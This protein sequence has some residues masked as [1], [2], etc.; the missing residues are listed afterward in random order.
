[1]SEGF[2]LNSGLHIS[3]QLKVLEIYKW[4]LNHTIDE[5]SML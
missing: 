5:K 1:M 2:D 3:Y 4:S